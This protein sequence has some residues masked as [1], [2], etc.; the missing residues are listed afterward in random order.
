MRGTGFGAVEEARREVCFFT[1][2][3][4]YQEALTDPSY[5]GQI[6]ILTYPLVGNYGI[7]PER[8]ESDRIQVKGFIVRVVA[9]HPQ[10]PPA[11]P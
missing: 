7:D 6:L 5:A 3:T 11:P 4:G 9:D 10:H 1:S 2:M 8:Y